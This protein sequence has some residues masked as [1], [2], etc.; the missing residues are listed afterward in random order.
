[1]ETIALADQLGDR[2]INLLIGAAFGDGL[3]LLQLESPRLSEHPAGI[4][5]RLHV[6]SGLVKSDAQLWE[7][8]SL[9]RLLYSGSPPESFHARTRTRSLESR[10]VFRNYLHSRHTDTYPCG[11]L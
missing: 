9:T 4:A 1:M 10:I 2:K 3:S 8:E 11:L 5:A 7:G 6:G